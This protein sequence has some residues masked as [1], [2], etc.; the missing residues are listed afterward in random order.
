M[1]IEALVSTF[2][3]GNFWLWIT[4]FFVFIFKDSI[5]STVASIMIFW[6]NDI[7]DDDTLILDGRPA[8][9]V[10]IGIFKTT[11]YLYLID[12]DGNFVNG[13][14]MQIQ[15]VKLKDLKIEKALPLFDATLINLYKN[16]KIKTR[17]IVNEIK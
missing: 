14:R 6:G 11:F 13:T 9:V 12:S 10:R 2:V 1:D 7:N 8:R 5:A 4:G 15:N 17:E 16:D 3:G